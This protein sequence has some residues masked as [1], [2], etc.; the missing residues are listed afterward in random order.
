MSLTRR[1]SR[2]IADQLSRHQKLTGDSADLDVSDV[3]SV[4]S[5]GSSIYGG[6]DDKG[7][8]KRS[9][10]SLDM[11]RDPKDEP[12]QESDG[13]GASMTEAAISGSQPESGGHKRKGSSSGVTNRYRLYSYLRESRSG[14][15]TPKEQGRRRNISIEDGAG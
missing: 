5:V 14:S 9:R 15:K 1:Q 3:L 11:Y 10:F 7:A 8:R 6:G 12:S 4:I 2:K 13:A